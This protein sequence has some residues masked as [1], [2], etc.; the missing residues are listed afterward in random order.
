MANDS[1]EY[2]RIP[3][4]GR[5]DSNN[6]HEIR[7]QVEAALAEADGKP[8][9]FDASELISISSAGLRVLN[10][11]RKQ[12][13]EPLIV[14]EVSRDV[15]DIFEIT[16]FT[17]LFDVRR[18]MREISVDGCAVLGKGYFGTVYRL[19]ADTVVKVYHTPDAVALINNEQKLSKAAF[20][21]GIPTAICY[22]IVRVGND[23]GSVFELLDAATYFEQIRRTP[24][25][26][27]AIV[28]SYARLLKQ[29]HETEMDADTLPSAKER[30][31]GYLDTAQTVL[32][33]EAC[34]R[35]RSL[36]N[37]VP[38]SNHALHGDCHMNNVML[39]NGEPMLIDMDT[40]AVGNAIFDLGA[41]FF[42]Y[43]PFEEDEPGNTERVFGISAEM[44][45][46][47]WNET[48]R[49]Y[50]D[51]PEPSVLT[52]LKHRAELLGWL[53]FLNRMLTDFQGR[54]LTD[55]RTEHAVR[56]IEELLDIVTELAI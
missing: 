8:P 20:L 56:H 55:V 6:A 5:I 32:P 13:T 45:D 18:R 52:G 3:L 22:D 51:N 2:I 15:Y 44:A 10:I 26:R 23:Y 50:F 14:D 7:Q 31:S 42:C 4:K 40:L 37:A 43:K 35:F 41:L 34:A 36:L 27:Q 9:L 16:G 38:D 30:F 48:L 28:A 46:Y 24:E 12:Y 21:K 33:Q 25:D 17:N 47:I 53:S 49:V 39:V 11:I 19:D 1:Q 29:I 54:P